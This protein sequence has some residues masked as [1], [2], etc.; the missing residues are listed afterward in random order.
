LCKANE[1]VCNVV[2]LLQLITGLTAIAL[3][4]INA[5]WYIVSDDP[6]ARTSARHGIWYVIFGLI[7]AAAAFV[8]VGLFTG[9]SIASCSLLS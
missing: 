2:K 9:V 8:L 1:E 3:I 4:L 7:V 5:I 6:A